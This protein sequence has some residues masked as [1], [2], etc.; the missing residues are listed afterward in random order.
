VAFLL[1]LFFGTSWQEAP[2]R[3]GFFAQTE[4]K[5]K[6][7]KPDGIEELTFQGAA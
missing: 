4:K 1:N 2:P 7:R 3:Q 5:C 6:R